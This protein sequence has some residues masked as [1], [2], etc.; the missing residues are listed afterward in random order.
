MHECRCPRCGKLF[1]KLRLV[2]AHRV[3]VEVFCTR[4]KRLVV[5]AVWRKAA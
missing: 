2:E 4:C 5:V 3:E 1:A